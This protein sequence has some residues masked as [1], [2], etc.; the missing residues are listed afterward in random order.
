LLQFATENDG[1]FHWM[2]FFVTSQWVTSNWSVGENASSFLWDP[3][4]HNERCHL[5]DQNSKFQNFMVDL[6]NEFCH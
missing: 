6:A 1:P 3:F 5:Q 2:T 4:F